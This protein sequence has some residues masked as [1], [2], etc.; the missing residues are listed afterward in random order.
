MELI[1]VTFACWWAFD[2]VIVTSY[3]ARLPL[4]YDIDRM[5]K[6]QVASSVGWEERDA[7]QYAIMQE[8][9]RLLGKVQEMD[10]VEQAYRAKSVPMGFGS[11][12]SI[13]SLF[14]DNGDSIQVYGFRFEPDSKMF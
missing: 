4:G 11:V 14:N 1:L 8:E 12:G 2:P 3:V 7:D 13:N 9:E 6:L 10:G 5:V